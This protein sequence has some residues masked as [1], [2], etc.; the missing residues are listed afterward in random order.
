MKIVGYSVSDGKIKSSDN[1]V[2]ESKYVRFLLKKK[3]DT[4]RLFFSLE[5]ASEKLYALLNYNTA[6]V[7]ELRK[8]TKLYISPYHLRYVPEKFFSI[9]SARAFAY[10]GEIEKY[11]PDVIDDPYIIKDIGEQVYRTLE[12]IGLTPINFINT[13]K[14]YLSLN[15]DKIPPEQLMK[16]ATDPIRIRVIGEI[17]D[18]LNLEPIGY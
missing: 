14:H 5:T 16:Y 4:I 18:G 1:E 11:S 13:Q 7:E 10:Y 8:T 6:Q 17:V 3:P 15:G 9:K 2:A 12:D